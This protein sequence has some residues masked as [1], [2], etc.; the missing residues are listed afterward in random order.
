VFQ[1][2]PLKPYSEGEKDQNLRDSPRVRSSKKARGLR[3]VILDRTLTPRKADHLESS[4]S[5]TG[6]NS[7]DTSYSLPLTKE[8]RGRKGKP[9][10]KGPTWVLGKE[11][12]WRRPSGGLPPEA[13]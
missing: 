6:P 2:D 10:R 11:A 9:G 12:M 5:R 8:L 3:E 1:I 7:H 13:I 4:K